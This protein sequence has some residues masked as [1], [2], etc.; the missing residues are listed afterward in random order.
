MPPFIA[1]AACPHCGKLFNS[2]NLS[3]HVDLCL[4]SADVRRRVLLALRDP[5][6]PT[7]AVSGQRYN[8]RRSMFNAPGDAT[9]LQAYRGTWNA[10][11]AE[12]GLEPPLPYRAGRPKID[13]PQQ[14]KRARGNMKPATC[15]HCGKESTAAAM[16]RHVPVCVANPANHARYKALMTDYDNVGVTY[17]EYEARVVEHGAP[18][19]TSLR[20][21]TGMMAWDDI[22]AWFG[23][24]PAVTPANVR[25]CPNCGKTFKALGYA[26]H[27]R[28]C[29]DNA[30]ARMAVQE[31]QEETALIAYEARVLRE[32]LAQAQCLPVYA[33]H[34][35]RGGG[36]GYWVR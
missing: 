6:E 23:L 13:K 11:C 10:V 32:D 7:R 27:F 15:P 31:T 3:Q 29:S 35:A 19:V 4:S 12:F 30:E 26:H 22:L 34:A 8:A 25:T 21:M 20:R 16:G 18:A 1:D 33:P 9:L 28:K 36:V 5:D 17:S 14:E 24:E 2:R